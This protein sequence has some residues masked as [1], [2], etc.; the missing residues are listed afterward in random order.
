M[1]TASSKQTCAL[2]YQARRVN[3]GL[4]INLTT[5][6]NRKCY[7]LVCS[8][9]E[10]SRHVRI[11]VEHKEDPYVTVCTQIIKGWRWN[12]IFDVNSRSCH[13]N[14]SGLSRNTLAMDIARVS[15]SHW[16]ELIHISIYL[17]SL[18]LNHFP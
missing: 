17:F 9:F 12:P 8:R 7:A 14:K 11:H 1:R 18:V 10:Q 6:E 3:L 2:S 5:R 13:R 4:E 15:V 16:F